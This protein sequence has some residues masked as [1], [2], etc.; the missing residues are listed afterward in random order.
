MNEW[1]N[2]PYFT[3]V[4][5]KTRSFYI[6]PS[7]LR[8]A[9]ISINYGYSELQY[10]EYIYKSIVGVVSV[11]PQKCERGITPCTITK[12]N[13]LHHRADVSQFLFQQRNVFWS[14][15]RVPFNTARV[16]CTASHFT[17]HSQVSVDASHVVLL[18]WPPP[19]SPLDA[20][21][22]DHLLNTF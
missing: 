9:T 11:L 21:V 15:P 19:Q 16:G 13:G 22:K 6:Q 1:M 7:P 14:A 20:A 17:L 3:R 4:V 10:V 12:A 8:E 5:E 2:K 18:F